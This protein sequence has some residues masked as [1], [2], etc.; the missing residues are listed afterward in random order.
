[1]SDQDKRS[2]DIQ[3]DK[4]NQPNKP[5]PQEPLITDSTSP[6]VASPPAP[7]PPQVHPPQQDTHLT[8]IPSP[9]TGFSYIDTAGQIWHITSSDY[10]SLTQP[11]TTD[12]KPTLKSIA[13]LETILSNPRILHFCTHHPALDR[14]MVRC[15][16]LMGM[17]KSAMTRKEITP[18]A[19]VQS[20][21]VLDAWEKVLQQLEGKFAAE[22]LSMMS[23]REPGPVLTALNEAKLVVLQARLMIDLIKT[24]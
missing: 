11:L 4:N 1:M 22:G 23:G 12:Y 6:Q 17:I 2:S 19:L 7:P 18:T 5:T 24:G 13:I 14:D 15:Q 3:A 21:T 9:R 8:H 16:E 20:T 10:I